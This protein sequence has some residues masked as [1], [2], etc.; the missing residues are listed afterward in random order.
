MFSNIP[1]VFEMW[2]LNLIVVM[3]THVVISQISWSILHL[4]LFV[5]H[6]GCRWN[7]FLQEFSLSGASNWCNTFENFIE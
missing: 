6:K 7:I 4:S 2:L 3:N 5:H 1:P